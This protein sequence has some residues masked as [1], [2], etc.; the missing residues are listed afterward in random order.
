MMLKMENEKISMVDITEKPEVERIAIAEGSIKLKE[1][2]IFAIK[3]GEIKKG[4]PLINARYAA[5]NAVKKTSS[6]IFLA[7]PIPITNVDVQFNVDYDTNIIKIIVTVKSIGK[8]GVELEALNGV[9]VGLLSIWDMV[10]YLEKDEKGQYPTT[11]IFGVRVI[12]KIKRSL[13]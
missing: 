10:K 7:H 12:E 3:N 13:T 5:I 1:N 4:D 11:E 2:T 8:T 6:L 9:M